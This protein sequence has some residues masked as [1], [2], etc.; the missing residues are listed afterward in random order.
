MLQQPF[1]SILFMTPIYWLIAW[2][3][4]NTFLNT[5]QNQIDK[6]INLFLFESILRNSPVFPKPSSCILRQVFVHWCHLWHHRLLYH[7]PDCWPAR[8]T[9]LHHWQVL[10]TAPVGVYLNECPVPT[11][12]GRELPCYAAATTPF[13]LLSEKEENY[14]L[15]EQMKLLALQR[16]KT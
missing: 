13:I 7:P 6:V 1:V 10:C 9:N 5:Q 14:I 12:C 2:S 16:E 11:P 3:W 8:T 15:P 4:N